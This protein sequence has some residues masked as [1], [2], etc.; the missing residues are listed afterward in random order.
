MKVK[1]GF[2]LRQVGGKTVVLATGRA[3]VSFNGMITLNGTGEF[4]W[5]ELNRDCSEDE[6]VAALRA[7][8]DVDEKTA[9]VD[10]RNFIQTMLDN[11]LLEV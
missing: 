10:V 8:Y 6:L 4:L 11:K 5:N 1:D 3:A 7:N 2:V 9:R